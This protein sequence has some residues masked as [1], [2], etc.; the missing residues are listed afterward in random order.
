MSVA[1]VVV[2]LLDRKTAAGDTAAA[3]AAVDCLLHQAPTRDAEQN[4]LT[5]GNVMVCHKSGR[6]VHTA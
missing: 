2:H 3:A 4:R 5:V 1:A 6:K